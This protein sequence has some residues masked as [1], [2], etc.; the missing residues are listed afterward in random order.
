M[1]VINQ[2]LKDLDQRS[3]EP[4]ALGMQPNNVSQAHSPVKIAAVTAISVFIV[5][6][7]GFYVWQLISE[8]KA[9]KAERSFNKAVAAQMT[10]VE[11]IA[12]VTSEPTIKETET[13]SEPDKKVELVKQ[14]NS[15]TSKVQQVNSNKTVASSA[16]PFKSQPFSTEQV[17]TQPT[18]SKAVINNSVSKVTPAKP[19][20]KITAVEE[21]GHSHPHKKSVVK[22][23]KSAVTA[24]KA[25]ANKMSVSRR[26]LSANELAQQKLALAEKALQAKQISKAEKLLED[27]VLI[28][29]NDSQTRQKLAALWF[30]RQAYQDAVNLLSQGLALN[31]QDSSLRMMQA[32]IY[33][34]QGKVKAALNA[35]KPLAQ[36]KDEQYQVMLAN[37]AQQ[38]QHLDAAVNAYQ[39]LISMQ[40][41]MGRWQLGLAVL[42]DKNSQ[43]NL[44]SEAYKKALTKNDLSVSS[45]QFVKER[46]QVIGQ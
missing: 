41:E 22:E 10:P 14:S 11:K 5:C 6:L 31:R 46:I 1:S 19:V 27:V 38:A 32:R 4:N 17:S 20:K 12:E 33:L 16:Q 43:F 29:P 9:L 13:L 42:H 26:Q 15:T 3:P 37:T 7:I 30:G 21:H 44:A 34:T 2:M 35:L 23:A 24:P 45:E 8:N 40:P 36:L 39:V 28:T 18:T 25:R